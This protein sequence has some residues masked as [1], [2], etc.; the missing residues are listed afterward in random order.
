MTPPH[1]EGPPATGPTEGPRAPT[2][3][4]AHVPGLDGLRGVA[5]LMV[6]TTHM[7]LVLI[8]SHVA[9]VFVGGFLGVE[10][11]FVLS[12][13]LITSLLLSEHARSGRISFHRFYL[14]RAL[15]LLPALVVL[16][17]VHLVYAALTGLDLRLE[18]HTVLVAI[19]YVSNWTTAG[20]HEVTSGLVHLWSL[21][22]EEQFYLVWPIVTAAMV[23]WRWSR[24]FAIAIIAVAIAALTVRTA[25]QWKPGTN[26]FNINSIY[27]RTDTQAVELLAG[28]AAAYVWARYPLPRRAL[29]LL[30]TASA[31][32]VAFCAWELGVTKGFYYRGGL[33]LIA[34]AGSLV[35]LATVSGEWMLARALSW[36][37][38]RAVG[39]VSYG[40]YLWHLPIFFEVHRHAGSW[41]TA[42]QVLLALGITAG[43]TVASWRLV[44]TPFLRRKATLAWA[45]PAAT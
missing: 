28:A 23:S 39:R 19:F 3:S 25:I 5:V 44:E 43:A 11:F 37:P 45:A 7:M 8:P 30:A 12:G 6:L 1:Q 26:F 27:V 21:A 18:L 9:D 31:V 32:F 10:L 34:I 42:L 17:F 20:G 38:L 13:F 22:V 4:F 16:L 41:P 36:R 14:R 33:T 40:L 29:H 2:R 15:R 35:V 24:R